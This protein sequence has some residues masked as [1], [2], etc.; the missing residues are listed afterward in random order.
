MSHVDLDGLHIDHRWCPGWTRTVV[1]GR[2]GWCAGRRC[3]G[4]A[5]DAVVVFPVLV[6]AEGAAVPRQVASA[7]GL[8]GLPAAVPTILIEE[9]VLN[10][11]IHT[12]K[13]IEVI[14][15]TLESLAINVMGGGP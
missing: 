6:L 1:C 4:L 9:N 12:G 3:G 13:C 11:K 15:G 5:A 2:P 10:G 14:V 7:A 8:V